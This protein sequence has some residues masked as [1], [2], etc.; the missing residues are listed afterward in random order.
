MPRL[1]PLLLVALALAGCREALTAP[2]LATDPDP[3]DV[4]AD[5][6]S[7]YVKAPDQLVQGEVV[8]VRAEPGGGAT[9]YTWSIDGLGDLTFQQNDPYGRH[10][11]L[12]AVGVEPGP[13]LITARAYDAAGTPLAVGSKAVEVLRQ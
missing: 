11:V 13:L 6:R 7:M 12:A 3:I 10:R 1:L 2:D 8:D 4:P 9:Y 5:V